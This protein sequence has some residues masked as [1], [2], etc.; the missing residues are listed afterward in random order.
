MTVN[1]PAVTRTPLD[2]LRWAAADAWT[3]TVRG[4]QQWVRQPT[5]VVAGLAFM[6][7]LVVLFG[8]LF[9]GAMSVPGGNYMEFLMPG[10]FAM[11]MVFGI[12]ETMVAVTTD[13]DKGVT[14]R[15]R[16]MPMAQSAVVVGRS[17]TDILY[18]SVGLTIMVATGLVVGWRWRSGAG[19]ALAAVGLLLLLRFAVQWVGI[20]LGLVIKGAGA[21]AAVQTLLYPFAMVTNTFA[22]PET[23]PAWLGAAAAWNPLSST[24]S[25]TRELFGNPGWGGES[26]LAQHAVLMA[27]VWPLLL[28]AVF[29]PLS[30][31][32]YRRLSR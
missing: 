5:Q 10:M 15:F 13:A 23:M 18:S 4:L 6:I 1:T 7:M 25:A 3:L 9:G 12:G 20:Y 16:S 17:V 26:W 32:R 31:W 29:L 11:T 19:E 30:V 21:A 2:R 22:A 27:I 14:D 8:Y 28:T 24:I